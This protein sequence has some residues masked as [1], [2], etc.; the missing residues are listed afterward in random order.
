MYKKNINGVLLLDK[1]I[2]LSSNKIL[3]KVKKIFCAKKAGYIG[4]LDPLASGI[5]P[6]CFGECT[7]FSDYLSN[8][9][10]RY[11]VI[12]KLGITTST[13]DSYGI[14]LKNQI[15]KFSLFK[16]YESL[17]I[18]K[19]QLFQVTPSYS[20]VKYQGRPLYKYA[21]KNDFIP[22]ILRKIKIHQLNL[23]KY[24][25]KFIELDII[26]SKGTYIRRIIHD[27]GKL[28]QCGAHVI[29]L[30]RLQVHSYKIHETFTFEQLNYIIKNDFNKNHNIILNSFLLSIKNIFFTLPEVIIPN[31]NNIINIKNNIFYSYKKYPSIFRITI[32]NNNK[33][34][35]MAK[36]DKKKNIFFYKFLN[37][38]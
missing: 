6:I 25:S 26:C 30:R 9:N 19:N 10:K 24:N 27:L 37:I 16:L 29:F 1:P 38:N 20:A 23:I 5:L 28:L 12:A 32:Q 4:T 18:I 21:I 17:K 11:Y 7:K 15:V 3:Q 35:I 22:K 14:I 2:G 33:I 31:Y 34:F 8:S 13:Y 36:I